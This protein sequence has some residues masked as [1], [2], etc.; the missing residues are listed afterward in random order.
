MSV[1]LNQVTLSSKIIFQKAGRSSEITL[2]EKGKS[3]NKND[4]EMKLQN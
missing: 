1:L 4:E 3:G 2:R